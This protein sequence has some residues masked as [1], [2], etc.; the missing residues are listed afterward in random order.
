MKKQEQK[1]FRKCGTLFSFSLRSPFFFGYA[2]L[3]CGVLHL[4]GGARG[5]SNRLSFVRFAA[6]GMCFADYFFKKI[7]TTH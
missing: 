3:V 2:P 7:Q 1:A 4:C 5:G 6:H